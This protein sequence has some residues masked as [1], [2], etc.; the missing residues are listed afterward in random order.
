M[1]M[2]TQ[3]SIYERAV[4]RV[5]ALKKFYRNLTSYAIVIS[6]LAL[7]NYTDDQWEEPWFLWV[8][9]LWGLGLFFEALKVYGIRLL[10]SKDWEDRKIR[11][12]MRDEDEQMRKH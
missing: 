1:E 10:F 3:E 4:E 6:L 5:E 11:Q 9:L 2:K 12:F 7:L 8:A